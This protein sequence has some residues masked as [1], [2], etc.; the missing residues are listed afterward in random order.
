MDDNVIDSNVTVTPECRETPLD[1][2]VEEEESDWDSVVITAVYTP[3][4]GDGESSIHPFYPPEIK[5]PAPWEVDVAFPPHYLTKINPELDGF[6]IVDT[7]ME[8]SK[9]SSGRKSGAPA[10]PPFY[11]KNGG[12]LNYFIDAK[13]R[14]QLDNNREALAEKWALPDNINIIRP[15]NLDTVRFPPPNCI[16]VY[17]PAFELGLRF[18][19]HP[20]IRDLLKLL[21]V[22]V[23][24]VYPNAWGCVT[25][26][27]MVCK[28]LK[29]KP[30]LTA[31]RYIFRVR[32]CSSEEHGAG[33]VTIAHRRGFKLVGELPDNQKGY[34]TKF[35][36]FV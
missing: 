13:T 19:L 26:F 2:N 27:L 25:A 22:T 20:F 4:R 24:E 7:N 5:Y 6:L 12:P 10:P 1:H 35:A 14:N 29:I 15:A 3:V 18:P 21:N 32:L 23:A 30:T 34:R 8:Q 36:F 9:D 33:W 31:F 16:A 11:I 17:M 28:V